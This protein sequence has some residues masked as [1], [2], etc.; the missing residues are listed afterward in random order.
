MTI[1]RDRLVR[2]FDE[3]GQRLATPATICVIGSTP[4]IVL[5]Q[6]GRQSQDIDIWRPNSKYDETQF[7]RAC[8]ELGL[9]YDPRSELDPKAIYVQIVRPG[10]VNLPQDIK[11]EILGEYGALTVAMPAPALLSAAKLVRGDPR[12]IEDVA[13]WIKERKLDLEEI[14]TAVGTLPD[15]TQ[16]E[17]AAENMVLVGLVTPSGRARR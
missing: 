5:G 11:V 12:D 8:L 14:R 16:R 15:L 13:W 4:G 9:L 2:I 3:L 17:I 7:R 10:L 1:D 6:P